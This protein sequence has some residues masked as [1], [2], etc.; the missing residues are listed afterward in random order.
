MIALSKEDNVKMFGRLKARNKELNDNLY[1]IK[2]DNK[3]LQ[4][5][6]ERLTRENMQLR[7]RLEY[8]LSIAN[9]EEPIEDHE[10]YPYL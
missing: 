9:G 10:P 8:W 5:K 4:N 6:N 2:Q 7:Q 1:N 3:E